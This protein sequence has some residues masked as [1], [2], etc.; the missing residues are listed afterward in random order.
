MRFL[1]PVTMAGVLLLPMA[2]ACADDAPPDPNEVV[3]TAPLA[4]TR[5]DVIAGISVIAGT[6]LARDLRSTVAD[7]LAHLPGVTSSSFG[8]SASRPILRGFQGARI[9]VLSDGVGSFDVSS[10]SVD[11]AVIINPLLA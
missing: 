8:P 3:V 7:T 2:A 9:R 6:D 10:T 4:R 5:E 1:V 11:H